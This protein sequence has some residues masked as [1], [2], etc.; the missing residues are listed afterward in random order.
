[1]FITKS[2]VSRRT[3]LR[4]IGATLSLP[5][6][7]AMVPAL[8]P[9]ALT[10]ATPTKRFGAIFVPMGERPS[11]W[12]PSTSGANFEFSPILKPIEK[13]RDYV[14][15]V[16]NIDRPLAGTHAVSTG[17]WLTGAA[18][19]R[20]EAEDFIAGT[21][22]DQLIAAQIAKDTVFPSL[23]I[24]T[25][26]Q[27]GYV[28]ACDVGYSCAY[29]STISWKAPTVP[30]P[31]E[32]NPRV[33]FERMFGRPGS[34]DDR[35]LRMRQ[36]RSILDSVRGDVSSLEKGLGARDRVRLDQYL[37]HVREVEGR[38]QRAEK[39]ATTDLE[40]PLAPVGIPDRWEEHATLMFD[41]MALA[42][43]ADLTRV[44]SFMLN[45]EA[46]QLVFPDLGFN[47]P[48]HHVSH[49]G[50]EPEKLALLVKLNTFQISL[51]GKFLDRLKE[52]PDGDG[53][54]LD[55]SVIVWGSGMSDSNTHS[56]LD[57]PYLMVGKGAGA[58]VGNRHLV[59]PK[60]AQLANVMLTVAQ[61]YGVEI[62][63]FGVSTGAFAI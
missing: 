29:M 14:N 31:M 11:H 19:K 57:V 5:L 37:E 40:I 45:R 63:K 2:S 1:M 49:H 18:P 25:E 35:L 17:T 33:V 38:I 61:K 20:T 51:F 10:A 59:A 56:P 23:E 48:W 27:S 22:L 15:V 52:T 32:T 16:S 30:M 3:V 53:S 41:L 34:A 42:Y 12:T 6:L 47:E 39:K 28:G 9:L 44:F 43:E 50:N 8:T 4:G 36:N 54:L 46:S 21:S 60:G 7:D 26:D 13:F 55:H 62:D 24:A 58:F